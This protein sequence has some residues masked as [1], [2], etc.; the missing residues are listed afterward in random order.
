MSKT[1]IALFI[2]VLLTACTAQTPSTIKIGGLYGLTGISQQFGQD[3]LRGT[4]LAIEEINAAG[5]IQ[6]K[7]LEL[8]A[9]DGQ[10]DKMAN[11]NGYRKLVDV[12]KIHYII[13][14]TW[15]Q[16]AHVLVPLIDQDNV[17]LISPSSGEFEYTELNNKDFF[18]TYPPYRDE[19]NVMIAYMEQHNVHRVAIVRSDGTFEQSM[20]AG[21]ADNSRGNISIVSENVVTYEDTDFH[22]LIAKLQQQDIDAIYLV[23]GNYAGVG[24]FF[25]QAKAAGIKL[26]IYTYSGCEDQSLL[27]T[28]GSAIEG[29]LYPHSDISDR[30]KVF[31]AKFNVRFGSEPLTPVAATAYDAVK[32]LAMGL[33]QGSSVDQVSDAMHAIK[34]YEG[35]SPITGFTTDGWPKTNRQYSMKTVQNGA[36]AQI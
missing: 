25:K 19:T 18:K 32:M 9:E 10:T 29:M 13:G 12:D 3:E 23:H 2:A 31:N 4:Q 8:I 11:L 16:P 6:G 21:F 33:E 24:E 26:P 20:S 27:H 1:F 22:T 34:N 7:Q 5:G 15:T 30:D 17:L 28:Y 14:P 36:F 35:A